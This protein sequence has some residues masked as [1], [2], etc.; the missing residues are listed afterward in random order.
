MKN[1]ASCKAIIY[2]SKECQKESWRKGHKETCAKISNPQNAADE[3]CH[4]FTMW[5]PSFVYATTWSLDLKNNPGHNMK[6]ALML[7]V[8]KTDSTDPAHRY[9]IIGQ[10]FVPLST[11]KH[12]KR[13]APEHFVISVHEPSTLAESHL[14]WNNRAWNLLPSM[15]SN[16]GSALLA[17]LAVPI[18][19]HLTE[20]VSHI[21]AM[22]MWDHNVW[23]SHPHPL[24][25]PEEMVVL[26]EEVA[27][28]LE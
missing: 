23:L 24:V 7:F 19:R 5:S 6:H 9:K 4:W 27:R 16:P 12:V 17:K 14:M 3:L 22:M 20:T 2:C 28:T 13:V 8:E 15:L 11:H 18:L 25:Q 10:W 21:D 1:C 26:P